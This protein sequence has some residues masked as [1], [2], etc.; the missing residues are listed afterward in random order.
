MDKIIQEIEKFFLEQGLE[1]TEFRGHNN[2]KVFKYINGHYYMISRGKKSGYYLEATENRDWADKKLFEDMGQYKTPWDSN[3]I[4]IID[5]I[6]ADIIKCIIKE[7][8]VQVIDT[9]EEVYKVVG[10]YNKETPIEKIAEQL[11]RPL[12]AIIDCLKRCEF[13]EIAQ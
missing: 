4:E 1:E 11:D 6:K 13:S 12:A 2:E 10:L 3:S 8:Q 9:V 5:E 7:Y